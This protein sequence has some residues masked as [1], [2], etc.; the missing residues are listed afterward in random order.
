VD[1]R[2]DAWSGGQPGPWTRAR[3]TEWFIKGTEPGRRGAVDE[4]GLLYRRMCGGWRVDPVKAELGP[5][6]WK[7]DVEDW[8]RRARRG[9][10]VRG[11]HD[12]R[13]A[14]FWGES[15][16]GGPLAGPC[17]RPKPVVVQKPDPPKEDPDRGGGNGDDGDGG[18][19][20]GDGNG[21]GNGNGNGGGG[22]GD[23]GEG[24]GGD[25]GSADGAEAPPEDDGEDAAGD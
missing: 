8:L 22:G 7:A 4:D 12:S 23:A 21:N 13:T 5:D 25:D 24:P 19:G 15:S 16:W 1:E 20:G 17:P 6:R 3:T 18:N 14:Y 9:V 2:I 10:G 11:E